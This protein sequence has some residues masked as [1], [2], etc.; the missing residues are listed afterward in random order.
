MK[1]IHGYQTELD[2]SNKQHTA[3]LQYA[4]CARFVS[5]WGLPRSVAASCATGKQ[6]TAMDLHRELNALKQTDYPWML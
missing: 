1:V 6:P 5:T 3:R 2:L 4:G